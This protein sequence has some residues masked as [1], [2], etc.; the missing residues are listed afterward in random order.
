MLPKCTTLTCVNKYS[1]T[2]F[3]NLEARTEAQVENYLLCV[4][5]CTLWRML[6]D[7][8]RSVSCESTS[9]KSI[10]GQS[11]KNGADSR[12]TCAYTMDWFP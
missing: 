6:D 8:H 9:L 4:F 1:L 12:S 5:T 7:A 10:Q 2:A 11:E 3:Q